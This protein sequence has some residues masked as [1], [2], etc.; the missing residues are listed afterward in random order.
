LSFEQ[1][2]KT[3]TLYKCDEEYDSI[4]SYRVIEPLGMLPQLLLI[5]NTDEDE[6]NDIRKLAEK[7]KEL[8][9]GVIPGL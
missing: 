2:E 7:R 5:D 1:I 6:D 4:S 3:T 8:A 9:K